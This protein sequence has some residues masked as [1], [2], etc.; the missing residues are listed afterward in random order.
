MTSSAELFFLQTHSA[1]TI[2]YSSR[3][4]KRGPEDLAVKITIKHDAD[5]EDDKPVIGT[6]EIGPKDLKPLMHG[7]H[8]ARYGLDDE[9]TTPSVQ[10]INKVDPFEVKVKDSK[11]KSQGCLMVKLQWDPDE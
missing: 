9:D 5:G 6:A 4:S 7:L 1:A 3:T 8:F 2:T 11:G 10:L